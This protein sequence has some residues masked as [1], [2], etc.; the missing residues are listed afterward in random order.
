MSQ[1]RASLVERIDQEALPGKD[2]GNIVVREF[3][4]FMVY[5]GQNAL[6]NEK[7]VR[8]HQHREC[9]WLHALGS[10]GSHVILCHAGIHPTFTDEAIRFAAELAI[11]FSRSRGKSV[12]YSRL[13]NVIKPP[14]G[15]VG[16][17]RPLKIVQLDI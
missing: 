16:V 8:D 15:G 17:F 7:I 4:G 1:V 11:R 6:T 12:M 3:N 2:D 9:C 14:N 13:E 10:R 5:V